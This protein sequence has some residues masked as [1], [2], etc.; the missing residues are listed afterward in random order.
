MSAERYRPAIKQETFGNTQDTRCHYVVITGKRPGI[1]TDIAEAREQLEG[2]PGSNYIKCEDRTSAVDLMRINGIATDSIRLFRGAFEPQ[3]NF[4]P[5]PTATFKD[6]FRRF[7]STQ[8]WTQEET[9]KARVDAIRDEIIKHCLPNGVRVLNE[10]DVDEKGDVRLDEEQY[11]EVYQAMCRRAGKRVRRTIDDN[12]LELHDKPYVNILD[13]IDAFRMGQKLRT[14]QKWRDFAAYTRKGRKM[15]VLYAKENEFLAPLLQDLTK[16]PGA[17]DPCAVRRRHMAKRTKRTKRAKKERRQKCKRQSTPPVST[18]EL[19]RDLSPSVF[20]RA[21]SP[22]VPELPDDH[23]STPGQSQVDC[24]VS[25]PP[26][27]EADTE[28]DSASDVFEDEEVIRMVTQASQV[29]KSEVPAEAF[30]TEVLDEYGSD[31]EVFEEVVKLEA[32]Q[33]ELFQ[34]ESSQKHFPATS[35][36]LAQGRKKIKLET[37]ASVPFVSSQRAFVDHQIPIST[38]QTGLDLSD[39]AVI[40][41]RPETPPSLIWSATSRTGVSPSEDDRTPN[42]PTRCAKSPTKKRSGRKRKLITSPGVLRSIKRACTNSRGL[43]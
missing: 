13:L 9:R 34:I 33:P 40:E 22:L 14:F 6:E 26:A 19:P 43:T 29:S 25:N 24:S 5:N 7:A 2:F 42:S 20:D 11:L 36:D 4:V 16:G 27:D 41:E 10:Q 12:L 1:Y 23:L 21:S 35:Q 28:F 38:P 37:M 17:V 30:E 39:P 32:T 18:A 3:I 15:D 31:S 8:Q